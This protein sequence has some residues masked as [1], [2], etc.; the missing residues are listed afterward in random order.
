MNKSKKNKL[1]RI[2]IA[3]GSGSGKSFIAEIIKKKLKNIPVEIVKLDRFFKPVPK[4]PKYWS[5]YHQKYCADF[6]QP[7][8]FKFKEMVSSCKKMKGSKVI[9][10]DGH[11]AL[12]FPQL[13]RLFDIKCFVDAEIPEM[14]SRRLKRNLSVG[15]GGSKEVILNY[16][17]ECVIPRYEQYILPTRKYA[18]FVIPNFSS[19]K[20]KRDKIIGKI[21]RKILVLKK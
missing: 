7:K 21:C 12:Y 19:S 9:L 18:D 15:Y 1:I 6:N 10:F 14:L 5:K 3:G 2:A 13:R 8:S 17:R 4:L 20:A 11:F 16:N